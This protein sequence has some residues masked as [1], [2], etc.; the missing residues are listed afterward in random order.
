MAF[1]KVLLVLDDDVSRKDLET[2]LQSRYDVG[3]V[4]TTAAARNKLSKENFDL[5]IADVALVNGEDKLFE[6]LKSSSTAP[7][8]LVISEFGQVE[9]AVEAL[10]QGAFAYLLRPFSSRQLDAILK[11]TEEQAHL[12]KVKEHLNRGN[13]PD[14]D[15]EP[16]GQ[17]SA[18]NRMRALIRKVARTDA[19]VLI[20]G[21]SGAGKEFA[22]RAIFAQSPRAGATFIK[23]DCAAIPEKLL[24]A[25]LFGSGSAAPGSKGSH[26]AGAGCFEL[27][28]GGAILLDEISLIPPSVQAKLLAVLQKKE[29]DGARGKRPLA[30]DARIIATTNRHLEEQVKRK[31][32]R[33]DLYLA[34]NIVPIIVPPLRDRKD[35]IPLLVEHFR[36][37]FSR[38]R[39]IET[40]A[41]SPACLNVLQNYS[42]PGNV[43]ELQ[44]TVERAVLLSEG[45]LHPEHFGISVPSQAESSADSP[46]TEQSESLAEI[47]KQH[48]FAVLDKCDGNRTHAAMRLGIS[49]RTLRNKLR[50]Y[51]LAEAKKSSNDCAIE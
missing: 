4:A 15:T 24:E 9:S 11:K 25:T 39:G 45:A 42:W 16:L 5:I 3:A 18:I 29:I 8:L 51:K 31:E 30:I 50:D 40:L 19:T 46:E 37:R 7:V 34:L 32:L 35:D 13:L 20:Q 12:L 43:R 38:Q 48:I 41:L 17:S 2:Q 28:R 27:A 1:D 26:C 49:I 36:Q 44:S 10:N 23:V 47:E 33:E 22:A 14:L 21:E 6:E